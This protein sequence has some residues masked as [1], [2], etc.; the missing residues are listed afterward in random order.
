VQ[1]NAAREATVH[2]D[3]ET[4]LTADPDIPG[5]AAI[6]FHSVQLEGLALFGASGF[7]SPLPHQIQKRPAIAGLFAF[8]EQNS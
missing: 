7:K 2:N 3:R 4:L 1:P 6:G 8:H 5:S